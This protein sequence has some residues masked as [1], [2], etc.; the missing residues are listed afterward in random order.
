MIVG[1]TG[2]IGSGKTTILKQFEQFKNVAIYMAD[3]EAR[4]VINTSKT[5]RKE[6]IKEFGEQAYVDNHINRPFIANIVFKDSAKLAKLNAITHPI[7][8]EHFQ[9]FI[10]HHR[11]KSYIVYE[12]AILFEIGSDAL[13]DKVITVTAPIENRIERVMKRDNTTKAEIENRIKNQWI[14][15]KKIIQSHYIIENIIL[16]ESVLKVLEIHNKLTKNRL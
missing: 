6:I 1:L 13:C 5:I 9:N 12:N 10:K 3:Q 7:V 11:T 16:E 8:K 4:N 15:A 14:E 2:G